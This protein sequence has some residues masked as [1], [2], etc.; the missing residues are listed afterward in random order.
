MN[1]AMQPS[2]ACGYGTKITIKLTSNTGVSCCENNLNIVFKCKGHFYALDLASIM[3][4]SAM[5][6][7]LHEVNIM[8]F[9]LLAVCNI[10]F[11]PQGRTIFL[12]QK[13]FSIEQKEK[14]ILI[15]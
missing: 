5:N 14:F 3:I 11:Y 7:V 6:F 10:I 12:S 2:F 4:N 8:R 9:S 13:S 1:N 15:F